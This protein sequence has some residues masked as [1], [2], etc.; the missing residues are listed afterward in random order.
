MRK[1]F[2]TQIL[3][4]DKMIEKMTQDG[5]IVNLK[6]LDEEIYWIA[7]KQNYGRK[8]SNKINIRICRSFGSDSNFSG[9]HRY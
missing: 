6:K 1:K 2:K 9:C 3:V 4:R 8:R 7:A 5:I